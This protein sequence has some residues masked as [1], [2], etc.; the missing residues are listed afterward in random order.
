M[1]AIA[2]APHQLRLTIDPATL[3]FAT[4]A[5]LAGEPLP[6]IGQERAHAAAQFGLNLQQPDYHLF[7]LG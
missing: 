7:V 6:W 5:E 2:L 1:P 4:T 3:G